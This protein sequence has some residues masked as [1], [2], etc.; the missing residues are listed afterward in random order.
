MDA[1]L[2]AEYDTCAELSCLRHLRELKADG[3]AITSLAGLEELDGLTRLSVKDNQ[4]SE[5][6]FEGYR[7]WGMLLRVLGDT[8]D[9]LG[10]GWSC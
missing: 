6:D 9:G 2:I 3:N 1:L 5:V 4:I 8:D 10:R 7:W